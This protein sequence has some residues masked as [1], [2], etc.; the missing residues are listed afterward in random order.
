MSPVGVWHVWSLTAWGV[1]VPA[2]LQIP[3]AVLGAVGMLGLT[4]PRLRARIGPPDRHRAP[5]AAQPAALAGDAAAAAVADR[6]LAQPAAECRL[7]VR[8]RQA[9]DRRAAAKL[10]VAARRAVQHAV[11][12]LYRVGGIRLRSPTAAM[13]LFN[14]ALLC[15]S[16]MLLA[17]A[18]AGRTPTL[19]WW[20]CAHGLLLAIPLNPGFVPRTFFASYGEAPLAVTTMFA[21]WLAVEVT[22]RPGTR[23]RMATRHRRPG[24]RPGGAGEHQAVGHRA[25][26]VDRCGPAALVARA[27]P[28]STPSRHRGDRGGAAPGAGAGTDLA[29][30]RAA[31]PRG[32][33]TEAAGIR[34]LEH[35][36]LP[37]IVGSMAR[38]VDQKATFFLFVAAVLGAAAWQ[39]RRD[40]WSRRGLLVG[41][42]AGVIV[43]FNGFLVVT[44]VVLFPADMAADAHSYFRYASQLSLVVMLALTVAL[45]PFAATL[46]GAARTRARSCR[47][48]VRRADPGG[49]A[50][51]RGHAALRSRSAAAAA[52][53]PRPS[54]GAPCAARRPAGAAGAGRCQRLGRQHAARRVAVHPAAT[55]G[56]RHRRPRP[57]PMRPRS[58]RSPRR[59]TRWRWSVAPRWARRRAARCRGSAASHRRWR[60]DRWRYGHIPPTSPGGG[61]PLCSRGA[62]SAPTTHGCALS[63][64]GE[65]SRPDRCV[66]RSHAS[67]PPPAAPPSARALR[68][69]H[70]RGRRC[71]ASRARCGR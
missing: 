58:M 38:E 20:A 71:P 30:V 47:G 37:Q 6:Y 60:G 64:T 51:H 50:R 10:L 26:A 57:R 22:S 7:S 9:A 61:S 11:R 25:S 14:V 62:R 56:T 45:R 12:G 5:A 24:P 3:L 4:H 52:M 53:G 32:G 41:M 13:A 67:R 21:V 35:R 16:G 31:Q 28:D 43:L 2:T 39:W 36:L 19:S 55:A 17:R 1:L 59:A 66:A 40:P 29:G 65:S 15:A 34:R 54:G 63:P 68:A 18:V 49:A 27:S 23:H 33:R 8:P 44:Y 48:R 69:S 70:R 46:A 42:A